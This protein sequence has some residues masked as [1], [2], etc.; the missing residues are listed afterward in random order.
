MIVKELE[1]V[2]LLIAEDDQNSA[3]LLIDFFS[4]KSSAEIMHVTNGSDAINVANQGNFDVV[5]VDLRL[6]GENGFVITE[7]IKKSDNM[8]P[9]AIIVVSAFHDRDYRIRALSLG[10][11]AF[12]GKPVDLKELFLVVKNFSMQRKKYVADGGITR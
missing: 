9:P 7:H 6:P 3:R 4:M 12:F 1:N 11:D 8:L 10:A 2:K 5:I